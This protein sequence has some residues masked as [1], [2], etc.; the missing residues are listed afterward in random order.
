MVFV[1]HAGRCPWRAALSIVSLAVVVA[2]ATAVGPALS[3][4]PRQTE[5]PT[6]A[7]R[8]GAVLAG[9]VLDVDTR[10]PIA[11]GLVVVTNEA[12]GCQQVATS[13]PDGPYE[14]RGLADSS[15]S[16]RA[17]AIGYAGRRYGQRHAFDAGVIVDLS[18]S[19]VFSDV[20]FALRRGGT[21]RGLVI[22]QTGSP[23]ELIEVEALRPQVRSSQCILV[24]I[25]SAQS[26]VTGT[27]RITGLPPG[28]YYVGT[29]DPADE[30]ALDEVGGPTHTFHPKVR[31]PGDA[32]R[33]RVAR[34]RIGDG[35]RHHRAGCLERSRQRPADGRGRH[36]VAVSG[37]HHEP[38][39]WRLDEP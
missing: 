14:V 3:Q 23:L 5:S 30:D 1:R 18:P 17:S 11:G 31:T 16:L 38:G 6:A 12:S 36:R 9:V 19:D 32:R 29:F 28:D 33:V 26:S 8:E 37:G 13:R 39:L 27:Y 7:A 4:A 22:D 10:A 25:N 20:D 34:E 35:Y 24:P 15:Y 21:I 2:P